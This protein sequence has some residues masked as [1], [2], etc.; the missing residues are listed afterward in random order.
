MNKRVDRV[1]FDVLL[2]APTG[3]VE[4]PVDVETVSARRPSA[5]TI[6]RCRQWFEGQGIVCHPTAFGLACSAP[7]PLF[8]SVFG[9]EVIETGGGPGRPPLEMS[10]PAQVPDVIEEMVEQITIG[11]AP[12]MF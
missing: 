1:E 10:R 4:R 8:E 12:E 5:E 9:V 3:Y 11:A 6:E 7:R 2:K